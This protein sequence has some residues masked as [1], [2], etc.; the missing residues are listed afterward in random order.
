MCWII[1]L[2]GEVVNLANATVIRVSRPDTANGQFSVQTW[3]TDADQD[4]FILFRN[5]DR[6]K[7]LDFITDLYNAKLKP[8]VLDR[9]PEPRELP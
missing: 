7:C 6:Q 3:F 9:A 1:T 5:H 2:A 4:G 8:Q